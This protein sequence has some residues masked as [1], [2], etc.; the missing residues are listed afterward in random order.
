MPPM[1]ELDGHVPWIIQCDCAVE[2]CYTADEKKSKAM[3]AV[4][5]GDL[6]AATHGVLRHILQ[7][8]VA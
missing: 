6:S 5:A 8:P 4:E 3:V 7:D 1:E 2:C